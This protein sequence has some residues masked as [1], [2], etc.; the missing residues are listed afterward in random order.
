MYSG[1]TNSLWVPISFLLCFCL[2]K[3]S[4]Y[5]GQTLCPKPVSLFLPPKCWSYWQELPTAPGCDCFSELRVLG[6]AAHQPCLCLEHHTLALPGTGWRCQQS[7]PSE[8]SCHG[9][10]SGWWQASCLTKATFGLYILYFHNINA[11]ERNF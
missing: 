2:K 7:D 8:V 9:G 5:V 4:C 3:G 1:S 6:R 10:S 11:I